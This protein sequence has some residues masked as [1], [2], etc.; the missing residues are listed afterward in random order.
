MTLAHEHAQIAHAS[1]RKLHT[2]TRKLHM[3][4]RRVY[5]ERVSTHGPRPERVSTHGDTGKSSIMNPVVIKSYHVCANCG[6]KL[7]EAYPSQ[8]GQIFILCA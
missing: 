2:S 1:T 5:K 4:I 3:S 8:K 7:G 6:W